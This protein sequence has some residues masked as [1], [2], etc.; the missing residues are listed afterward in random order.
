MT[1]ATEPSVGVDEIT[2]YMRLEG[3]LPSE[4]GPLAE[5]WIHP[6]R[7]ES[8]VWV[9]KIVRASDFSRRVEVLLSDLSRF[10]ERDVEAIQHD[11]AVVHFDV[12]SLKAKHPQLIDGSIPLPAG[13][14]LF[15]AAQKMVIAS[16]AATV[17]RQGHFGRRM[18]KLARDHARHVRLGQTRRGSYILPVI[19][20]AY[21]IPEETH[22]AGNEVHLD[23]EAEIELF[24]RRVA[25]TMARALSVLE[26]IAVEADREPTMAT[27]HDAVGEGVS[28]ELCLALSSIILV[29]EV[30]ELD[31]EFSW[32]RATPAPRNAAGEVTFPKESAEIVKDI[33]ERL[34]E[35]QRPREDVLFGLVTDLHQDSVQESRGG[36]VGI[37]TLIDRRLRTVWFDL[38]EEDH[39]IAQR[40][41]AERRRVMVRGILH[42]G[43]E[44]TMEVNSF[45]PDYSLESD[46]D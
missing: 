17:R 10:E 11:I 5:L 28:R 25:S 32:A 36:K 38:D 7:E 4:R 13:Y 2:T 6:S 20:R 35:I 40:C 15:Q 27:I 22:V 31:V 19:S 41:Y 42:P 29:D 23:V 21:A 14:E 34:K 18:P 33:G 39:R 12:T 43:R 16:A 3:W 1:S 26:E 37:E 44:T 9:P 24:D 46:G 45:L 8:V 30:G